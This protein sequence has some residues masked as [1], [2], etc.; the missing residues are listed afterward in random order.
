[1][2][3][4]VKPGTPAALRSLILRCTEPSPPLRPTAAEALDQLRREF[5]E[6]PVDAAAGGDLRPLTAIIALL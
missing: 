3:L 1:M 4:A 2:R 5:A 6:Q